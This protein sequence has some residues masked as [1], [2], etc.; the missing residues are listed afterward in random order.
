MALKIASRK[1]QMMAI[2]VVYTDFFSK[3]FDRWFNSL[4]KHVVTP[5]QFFDL[6]NYLS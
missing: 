1:G 2:K 6:F 5:I 4:F 3:K